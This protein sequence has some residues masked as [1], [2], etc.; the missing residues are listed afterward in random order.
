MDI[1]IYLVSKMADH[2]GSA[3]AMIITSI[4]ILQNV[5]TVVIGNAIVVKSIVLVSLSLNKHTALKKLIN[6]RINAIP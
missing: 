3:N 6:D 4:I 2:E 5:V 1:D